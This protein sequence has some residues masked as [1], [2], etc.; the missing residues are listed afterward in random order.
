MEFQGPERLVAADQRQG[1]VRAGCGIRE[2]SSAVAANTVT[3]EEVQAD[4]NMLAMRDAAICAN[5]AAG[6]GTIKC[7]RTA[8]VDPVS[9]QVIAGTRPLESE[10]LR[11]VA[12]VI[13]G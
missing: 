13:A 11:A 8:T 4:V 6:A 7:A 3:T 10:R 12:R 9:A 5:A 1:A 2:A